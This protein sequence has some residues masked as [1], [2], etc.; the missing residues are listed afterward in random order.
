MV[1]DTTRADARAYLT[2]TGNADLLPILGLGPDPEAVEPGNCP[3]CKT[4]YAAG[5]TACRRKEC[6]TP[7]AD[8]PPPAAAEDRKRATPRPKRARRA[9]KTPTPT[10]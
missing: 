2:R 5:R 4:P 1:D 9:T 10:T 8:A 3:K 7:A 6:R